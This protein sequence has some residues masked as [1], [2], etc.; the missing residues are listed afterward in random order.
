M[1]TMRELTSAQHIKLVINNPR[2]GRIPS[3]TSVSLFKIH[4]V[5]YRS[6]EIILIVKIQHSQTLTST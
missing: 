2:K 6:H 1:T 3:Q 5:N 4:Y